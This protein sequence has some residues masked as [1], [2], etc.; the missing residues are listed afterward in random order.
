MLGRL[1][2]SVD[3]AINHYGVLSKQVFSK[4]KL[5]GDRKFMASELEKVIKNIVG[6]VTQDTEERMMDPR[7][8]GKLCRT[9][10][11]TLS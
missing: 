1:R 6:D 5:T 7:S 10:V 4:V 8:D 3:E 11:S 9:Y 2:M